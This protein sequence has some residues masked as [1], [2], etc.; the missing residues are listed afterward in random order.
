MVSLRLNKELAE[1]RQLLWAPS[2]NSAKSDG[3]LEGG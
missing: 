3:T 2:R 1:M